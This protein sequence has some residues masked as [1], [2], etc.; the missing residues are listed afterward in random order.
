M[1][2]RIY[3]EWINDRLPTE[4]DKAGFDYYFVYLRTSNE[5]LLL[6]SL[7]SDL[8]GLYWATADRNYS[9]EDYNLSNLEHIATPAECY[10]KKN[11]VHY[12]GETRSPAG[13]F[14]DKDGKETFPGEDHIAE[15][16]EK[17]IQ[18]NHEVFVKEIA[19]EI[20][21]EGGM[22]VPRNYGWT[23][24]N[25]P[26]EEGW[27][28]VQ[29]NDG[30]VRI[31]RFFEGEWIHAIVD[32]M[33]YYKKLNLSAPYVEPERE[34]RCPSCGNE[35]SLRQYKYGYPFSYV[36][37]KESCYFWFPLNEHSSS[38]RATKKAFEIYD[39]LNPKEGE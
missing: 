38:D 19:N 24:G 37:K 39:K 26:D 11:L 33:K 15:P 12:S 29:F 21:D 17:V 14:L 32:N 6:Q 36:C 2:K 16:I 10:R 18:R 22:L 34:L 28:Q 25:E 7:E 9:R 1:K 3:P 5:V 30:E 27:Y 13:V 8:E 20:N 4:E 23:P 31:D 35:A